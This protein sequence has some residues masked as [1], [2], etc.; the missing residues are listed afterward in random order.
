M[1]IQDQLLLVA[2]AA[3]E[4]ER[5][6]EHG[7]QPY[8]TSLKTFVQKCLPNSSVSPQESHLHQRVTRGSVRYSSTTIPPTFMDVTV[9]EVVLC[10]LEGTLRLEDLP[11]LRVVRLPP[12]SILRKELSARGVGQEPDF[13]ALENNYVTLDNSILWVLSKLVESDTEIKV[14][15]LDSSNLPLVY[16]TMSAPPIVTSGAQCSISLNCCM[17]THNSERSLFQHVLLRHR[18]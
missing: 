10:L 2:E 5:Y 9:W 16:D 6:C 11:A 4:E 1:S 18:H 3:D 13:L 12:L 15:E 7:M 14:I 17:K 8:R